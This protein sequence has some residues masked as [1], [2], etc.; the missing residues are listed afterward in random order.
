MQT[1]WGAGGTV[2]LWSEFRGVLRTPTQQQEGY[3][4][5]RNWTGA[6]ELKCKLIYI[7]LFIYLFNTGY[8]F[9]Y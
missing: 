8:L 4:P 5:P 7:L 2:S 1:L 9:I 3:R 6:P